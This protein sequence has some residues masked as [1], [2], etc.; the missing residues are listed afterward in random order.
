M[1][2][3]FPIVL[4]LLSF[5]TFWMPLRSENAEIYNVL[6]LV[7]ALSAVIT[8]IMGLLLSIGDNRSGEALQWHEWGGIS[9]A[10]IGFLFY[11]FHSFFENRKIVG[12]S[13][14][15]IAAAGLALTAHFGADLTHGDDYLLAPI[16]KEKKL[17][18][19]DKAIVF[20][21]VIKPIFERKCFGCHGEATIKGGLSLA[22]STG[23]TKGGKTGPLF[24]A[25]QA[26]L[27]LMIRRIHLPEDGKKTHATQIKTTTDR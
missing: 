13:F 2:L 8:A 26:S 22:D 9:I 24:I 11:S 5:F 18:P 27:S 21:D 1:F 7:A 10:I 16:E 14:T 25:G 15:I 3:H 17:V 12:K 20:Q 6:R 4:L 23:L 19:P